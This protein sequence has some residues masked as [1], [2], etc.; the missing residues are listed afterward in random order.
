MRS[1]IVVIFILSQI[2]NAQAQ[3]LNN[4]INIDV[5]LRGLVYSET[6]NLIYYLRPADPSDNIEPAVCIINPFNGTIESCINLTY[7]PDEMSMSIDENFIFVSHNNNYISKISTKTNSLIQIY[8]LSNDP[9]FGS[10][11]VVDI[12]ASSMDPEQYLLIID[13]SAS[14]ETGVALF[15][16]DKELAVEYVGGVSQIEFFVDGY[17]PNGRIFGINPY[18]GYPSLYSILLSD[19]NSFTL[20]RYKDIYPN[21]FIGIIG[22]VMMD[23][24]GELIDISMVPPSYI[25]G[26]LDVDFIINNVPFTSGVNGEKIVLLESQ[27]SNP[28]DPDLDYVFSIIDKETLEKEVEIPLDLGN[29]SYVG[30]ATLGSNNKIA[31]WSPQV[32]TLIS[33]C[34][35][36]EDLG[37]LLGPASGCEGDTLTITAPTGYDNYIWSNGM[38]GQQI[39]ISEEISLSFA[40]IDEEGCK[41]KESNPIFVEFLET[42]WFPFFDGDIP[43]NNNGEICKGDTAYLL[44]VSN[45]YDPVFDYFRWSTGDT[46]PTLAVTESGTY[47]LEA[48]GINGCNTLS[49]YVFDAIFTEDTIPDQPIIEVQR[50]TIAPCEELVT[51]IGPDGYDLYVWQYADNTQ[52]I[53][54]EFSGFYSLLVGSDI[55]CLS[56]PS[57]EVFI[58]LQEE[59]QKPLIQESGGVLA[60]SS[61]VGNQWFLNGEII[62]G[63]TSQ[64]YTPESSGFYSVQ[65]SIDD[66]LSPISELYSF[67][68]VSTLDTEFQNQLLVYPNPSSNKLFIEGLEDAPSANEIEVYS[69]FGIRLIKQKIFNTSTLELDLGSWPQGVYNL[70]VVNSKNEVIAERRVVKF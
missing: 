45:E 70:V 15:E 1:I 40:V 28:H 16:G 57:E 43:Y 66:C 26:F 2:V 55:A 21:G 42:P 29:Y 30:I 25:E 5:D 60:S 54:V 37:L 35:N 32:V 7:A 49:N 4:I 47:T 62:D 65:V 58:E 20:T 50:D 68:F 18:N 19:D 46:M 41:S 67:T 69:V 6:N 34:T 24:F 10:R 12:I 36:S 38:T 64:F 13:Y 14:Y 39:E 61:S 9:Q 33:G 51:L 53:E 56:D 31:L 59:V 48:I 63:A 17:G 3:E 8:E 52:S 22:D 11:R 44:A 27:F 23:D